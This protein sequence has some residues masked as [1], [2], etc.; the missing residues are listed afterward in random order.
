V[1]SA[2]NKCG[3]VFFDTECAP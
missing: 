1:Q 3:T 2:E